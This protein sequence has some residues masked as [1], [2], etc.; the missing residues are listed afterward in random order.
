MYSSTVFLTLL[1][2]GIIAIL[3]T[4]WRSQKHWLGRGQNGKNCNVI[5][6][7]I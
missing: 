5:L 7:T 2:N 3:Y 4:H 6:V 1:L